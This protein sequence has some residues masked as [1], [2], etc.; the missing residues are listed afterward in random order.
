M[1][2]VKEDIMHQAVEV[3]P[4]E[5]VEMRNLLIQVVRVV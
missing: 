1:M 3:V 2:A 5:L 4:V